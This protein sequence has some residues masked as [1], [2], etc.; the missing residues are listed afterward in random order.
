[1]SDDPARRAY[2]AVLLLLL[3]AFLCRVLA[4]LI[5]AVRPV[6]WLPPFEAWHSAT[7]PYGALVLSQVVIAAVCFWTIVGVLTGRT[8]ARRGLGGVLLA[9]GLLYAGVMAFRL[10]A[11]WTILREASWFQQPLATTFHLVLA[12]FVL[13]L[14]R[15]H[16][17]HGQGGSPSRGS[18]LSP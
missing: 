9:L 8:V 15:F 11:G 5:Q 18:R 1:M 16:L 12:A 2:A 7:L 3:A 6:G 14:A 17:R 4:Q 13:T 10:I